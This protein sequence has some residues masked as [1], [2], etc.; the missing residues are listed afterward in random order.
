MG[1]LKISRGNGNMNLRALI[2]WG[3][4]K[5]EFVVGQREEFF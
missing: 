4:V 5:K 3:I 1:V 2:A